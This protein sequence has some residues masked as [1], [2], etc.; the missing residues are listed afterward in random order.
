[1]IS[2]IFENDDTF[3]KKLVNDIWGDYLY[4]PLD[5][6]ET[7]YYKC[8]YGVKNLIKW[9]PVIWKDRDWDYIFLLRLIEKKLRFM[10]DD[11][12]K[13][14]IHEGDEEDIKN[15]RKCVEYCK[16]MVDDCNKPYHDIAFKEHYKKYKEYYDKKQF[17]NPLNIPLDIC[18]DWER[19]EKIR[20]LMI[21]GDEQ[22]FKEIFFNNYKKW[23]S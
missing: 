5:I 6:L 20:Q 1:M 9:F 7:Y 12:E 23:W 15:M 18:K 19:C 16:N 10:A 3:L 8:K 17:F 22:K 2:I 11:M 13:H 21:W 4:R 14:G